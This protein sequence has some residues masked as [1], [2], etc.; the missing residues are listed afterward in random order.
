MKRI[1]IAQ[2]KIKRRLVVVS[3]PY[4]K[5]GD[6]LTMNGAEWYVTK[7]TE[8]KGAISIKFPARASLHPEHKGRTQGAR[9]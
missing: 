8:A 1:V 6:C 3:D 4:P 9:P 2:G 7:V 5:V